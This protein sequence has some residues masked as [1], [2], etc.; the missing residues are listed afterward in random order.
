[1]LICKAISEVG[2]GEIRESIARRFHPAEY[3]TI[4]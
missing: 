2:A 3:Q 4:M 1:V